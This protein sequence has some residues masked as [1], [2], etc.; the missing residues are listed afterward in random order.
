MH[1]GV[2]SD[3]ICRF[4]SLTEQRSSV[5]IPMEARS[6]WTRANK[7]Y[8]RFVD[9]F[10]LVLRKGLGEVTSPRL[11]V[12]RW[13]GAFRLVGRPT[14]ETLYNSF[15]HYKHN[16]VGKTARDQ[17]SNARKLPIPFLFDVTRRRV[18]LCASFVTNVTHWSRD[19]INNTISSTEGVLSVIPINL[20]PPGTKPYTSWAQRKKRGCKNNNRQTNQSIPVQLQS[21]WVPDVSFA[22][23]KQTPWS[24]VRK[25]TIPTERPPFVDE[26]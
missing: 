26:I 18:P 7:E 2:R 12:K 5:W 19:V 6:Q 22:R 17:S 24:L 10:E 8:Y 13:W 20:T 15:L 11:S 3:C 4:R 9:V 16:S 25:R 1:W 21:E 23:F 14:V